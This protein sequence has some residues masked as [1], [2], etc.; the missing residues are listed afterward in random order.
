[1]GSG[2]YRG[3]GSYQ[4][5]GD[6]GPAAN[7]QEQLAE[8]DMSASKEH[9]NRSANYRPRG[10]FGIIWPVKRVRFNRGFHPADDPRHSGIDFGGVRGAIILAAHEGVVIYTGRDFRGYG[11]MMLIEYNDEWATLYGHLDSFLVSEGT[12]VSPGTAVATMGSTGRATGV[13]LH[14]ELM[15]NHEPIDPLPILTKDSG[16]TDYKRTVPSRKKRQSRR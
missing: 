14:F 7:S 9:L 3:M 13:H 1:M 12:I 16:F 5:P 2:G 10:A 4:T 15:H 11:N 6:Y 8:E